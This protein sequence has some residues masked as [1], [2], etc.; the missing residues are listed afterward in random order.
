MGRPRKNP[1]PQ[2]QPLNQETQQNQ[3]SKT[4]ETKPVEIVASVVNGGAAEVVAEMSTHKTEPEKPKEN[5]VE[6]LKAEIKGLQEWRL[7]VN[8]RLFK[9]CGFDEAKDKSY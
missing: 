9:L 5:E 2:I 6:K 1:L 3:A 4:E 8:F 7:K